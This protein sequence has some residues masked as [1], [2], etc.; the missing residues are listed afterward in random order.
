M[1]DPHDR[2]PGSL[3]MRFDTLA[4]HAG[5]APD[6]SH[7]GVMPSIVLSS[8]FA[9][10]APGVHQ[11]YDYSR[12][13]NPTRETL[14]RCLAA[15]EGAK[16]GLAFGSGVAALACVF[17]TL[18]PGDHVIACDDCYG[19][20]F[21]LLDKVLGPIGVQTSWVDMSDVTNVR[22]AVNSR[23]RWIWA[24]T[25]SN[26]TLK[27]L[28]IA[29]LAAIA[30]EE[31]V[32]LGVDNTFAT[33]VL[34][35][36]LALG[37]HLVAH[38]TTKYLNGH[39]DVVGGAL[40]VNDDELAQR[41]R[42]L[43]NAIGAVPSPFDC[44]LVLR[45]LKTLPVRMDRH[46]ANASILATFLESRPEI[47]RVHFPG[48]ASHPQYALAKRAM[49]GPGG[50]ISFVLRGGGAAARRFVTHTRLFTL[51]ESLG[52]VESLIEHPASMTHGSM[53]ADVRERN[54]VVDGLIRLSVG[55]EAV[56]DL[57]DDLTHALGLGLHVP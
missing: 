55:L 3:P 54:G 32:L 29:A 7:G 18:R 24:E 30:R 9:Q 36:P 27:V 20:T 51:A 40:L 25:P 28:D 53:P 11:G 19:G 49:R 6:P 48:L 57:R 46:V 34:Q 15:L 1:H 39:S 44:F 37:A 16:H 41:L 26:P 12:T 33:P 4:I 22:R 35:Q 23:T 10:T 43:Q 13:N 38:S 2:P 14:E 56:D 45:G 50:M 42:F 8:T 17:Q 52:G 5:Q 31:D 47:E 21:R